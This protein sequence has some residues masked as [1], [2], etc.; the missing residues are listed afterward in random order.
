MTEM[1]DNNFYAIWSEEDNQ[2][3]GLCAEFPGLCWLEPFVEDALKGIRRCVAENIAESEN[4]QLLPQER[5]STPLISS[6]LGETQ[7]PGAPL[8]V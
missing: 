4:Q 2:Y 5:D 7:T 6:A 3:V 8:S 1:D